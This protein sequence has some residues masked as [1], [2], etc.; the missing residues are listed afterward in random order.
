MSD[1]TKISESKQRGLSATV[2]AARGLSEPDVVDFLP[3]PVYP[4]LGVQV[5]CVRWQVIVQGMKKKGL[6]IRVHRESDRGG[7]FKAAS[8]VGVKLTS[9]RCSGVPGQDASWLVR[10]RQA[11][12]RNA[13][14]IDA[15]DP[16]ASDRGRYRAL[17][18][19]VLQRG[20][21]PL[22]RHDMAVALHRSLR[23]FIR[24]NALA[25]RRQRNAVVVTPGPAGEFVVSVAPNIRAAFADSEKNRT[26]AA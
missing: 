10:I 13:A 15:A 19:L 8:R 1:K 14:D 22:E 26:P 7:L 16:T 9:R 12:G 6:V 11:G 5:H 3:L 20:S 23:E 17:G 18:L 25:G 24:E 4:L 21:L 2:A